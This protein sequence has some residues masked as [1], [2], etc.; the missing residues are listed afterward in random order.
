MTIKGQRG[1]SLEAA[2]QGSVAVAAAGYPVGTRVV[3]RHVYDNRQNTQN[4]TVPKGYRTVWE[5]DRLNPRRA[6]RTTAPYTPRERTTLPKGYRVAWDDGR[7]NRNRGGTASGDSDTRLVWSDTVP[8]KLIRIPTDRQVVVVPQSQNVGLPRARTPVR[9]P[10]RASQSAT[11]QKATAPTS[12]PNPATTKPRYIRVATFGSDAEARAAGKALARRTG[13]SV[14][15]GTLTRKGKAYR[16]VMA[17]PY[18]TQASADT[19]MA[20]VRG[21]GYPRA[22]LGK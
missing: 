5:D 19:A 10:A 20:K 18:S 1:S 7:L 21:A 3:P 13:L 17:G 22:R 4:V 6:E 15:L 2:P 9:S 16:V 8:R 12:T 11:R 14:R